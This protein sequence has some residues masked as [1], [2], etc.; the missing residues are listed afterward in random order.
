MKAVVWTA[1]GPP[2]VLQ[3]REV[4]RPVPRDHG[5]LVAVRSTTVTAGEVEL[6]RFRF[7]SV[8]TV[9]LRLYIGLFRPRG[10]RI[11]GQEFAGDVVAVGDA[12][13]RFEVGD[14]VCA[15]AGFGFGGYGEY[16]TVGESGTVASIPEGVSYEDATTLPTAG[17]YANHFVTRAAPGPGQS[18]L[19][20]G[21]G[22][23]IGSF[24]IQLARRTG[25]EVTAVD[26]TDK[27]A[28]MTSLGANHV[29]DY[30]ERDFTKNLSAYDSILDVVDK[31]NF[32][33]AAPS[34][35]PGGTYLHSNLSLFR[36]LQSKLSRY[37]RDRHSR[38]VSEGET[39]DALNSLLGMV[40]NGELE[41]AI[42]RRYALEEIADA[43]EY[44]ETGQKRGHIVIQV[45]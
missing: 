7:W 5:L 28:I 18:V 29:I 4:A 21:G 42:D 31:S 45:N 11:P 9:P 30:T 26:R 33:R 36:L 40:A 14:R 27:L 32:H 1:Y 6:R 19:I 23:S 15:H 41:V 2:D 17:L 34:L 44:A 10:E 43:H 20:N 13:T 8:V 38:Y 37:R 3:L 25:A 35:K 12:V 22:G 16:A 39:R 24:A